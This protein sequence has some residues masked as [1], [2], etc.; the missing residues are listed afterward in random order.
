MKKTWYGS[1]TG[2][3][4]VAVIVLCVGFC[5][6]PPAMVMAG[7][8]TDA[9]LYRQLSQAAEGKGDM[10]SFATLITGARQVDWSPSEEAEFS[11]HLRIIRTKPGGDH[12]GQRGR[13]EGL[14]TIR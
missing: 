11:G 5:F 2:G 6:Y 10:A 4:A 13:W 9:A 3:F 1:Y 14:N 12:A 7:T 8:E